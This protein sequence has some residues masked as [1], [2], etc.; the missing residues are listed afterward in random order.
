VNIEQELRALPISFPPEPDLRAAVVARLE[1]STRRRIWPLVAVAAAA[2]LGGLLA[3]PDT[4]AAIERLLEIGGVRIERV[5]TQ[6]EAERSPLVTG[7]R[8]TREEARRAVAFELAPPEP[9]ERLYLDRGV[10]GGMV[11][12]VR[13]RVVLSQWEGAQTPWVE[14]QVGPASRWQS[15]DLDGARGVWITGAPHSMVY[16]DRIGQPRDHT[17]RLAGNV[18]I[19]ERGS[20]TY[21]L[22]GARTL[23]QALAIARNL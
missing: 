20:I 22:E 15:V 18:L 16:I 11:S 2:A 5:E 4:R 9:G 13:D 7:R 8:V 3:L 14:K 21:R 1:A 19:W 17:R 12:Y 23:E 6:P 10:P